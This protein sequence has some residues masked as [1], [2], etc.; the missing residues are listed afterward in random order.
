MVNITKKKID[1]TN[2]FVISWKETKFYGGFK[3]FV[4]NSVLLNYII[5]YLCF[6]FL[7]TPCPIFV[8]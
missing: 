3:L 5:I 7:P 2:L 6:C 8:V 1:N 4:L